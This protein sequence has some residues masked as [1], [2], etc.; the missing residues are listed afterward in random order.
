MDKFIEVFDFEVDYDTNKIKESETALISFYKISAIYLTEY[1]NCWAVIVSLDNRDTFCYS[2]CNSKE[3]AYQIL[4]ILKDKL[5]G[6]E[7]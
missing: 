3:N 5:N 2:L 6:K 7:N 1:S 4:N